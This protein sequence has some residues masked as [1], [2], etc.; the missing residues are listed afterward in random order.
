MQGVAARRPIFHTIFKDDLGFVPIARAVCTFIRPKYR[1]RHIRRLEPSQAQ[2]RPD[3]AGIES[4]GGHSCRYREFNHDLLPQRTAGSG[5]QK[6]IGWCQRRDVAGKMPALPGGGSSSQRTA[7][8]GQPK[9]K[10]RSIYISTLGERINR[11]AMRAG[12]PRSQGKQPGTPNLALVSPMWGDR[13]VAPTV[14][15]PESS[16]SDQCPGSSGR[17]A[18]GGIRLQICLL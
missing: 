4:S 12:R 5:Q 7:V 15:V 8:A 2:G 11:G 14:S 1:V 18:S 3:Q 9:A 13:P 16:Y 6:P 10:G 17:P